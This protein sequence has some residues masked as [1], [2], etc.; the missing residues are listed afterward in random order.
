VIASLLVA[1]LASPRQG[2]PESPRLAGLASE[3]AAGDAQALERFW[4]ELQAQGTPL[5]EP[6]GDP[7]HTLVTFVWRGEAETRNVVV[8]LDAEAASTS[9]SS[10]GS[11]RAT[12]GSTATAAE[13]GAVLL[14]V[15][16]DD[17]LVPFED[18]RDWATRTQDFRGDPLNP[19]GIVIGGSQSFSFAASC[20]TRRASRPTRA[21]R[22]S[23]GAASSPSTGLPARVEGA[24]QPHG[25]A[26][27]RRRTSSARAA[28]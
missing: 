25:L 6:G 19:K 14:P 2:A 11:P 3:L 21:T 1:L 17:S 9:S 7:A 27:F 18:E 26:L 10:R 12:C 16:P 24:R 4:A 15:S 5:Y 23:P 22:T 28:R 20:R 8:N 13:P